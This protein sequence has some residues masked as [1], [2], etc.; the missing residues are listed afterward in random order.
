MRF[1]LI[2]IAA[3]VGCREPQRRPVQPTAAP[4]P[5][6]RPTHWVTGLGFGHPTADA[7]MPQTIAPW[8]SYPIDAWKPAIEAYVPRVR[9]GNQTVLGTSAQVWASY[10]SQ[11]HR[12]LHLQYVNGFLAS[13]EGRPSSDPLSNKDLVAR[14]EVGVDEHGR[15]VALGIIKSSGVVAFDAAVL[16]SFQRAASFGKTPVQCMSA[17][18]I[19]YFHWEMHRGE[20]ECSPAGASPYLLK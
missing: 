19:A 1:A 20:Q 14:V 4:A 10:L 12:A 18:G 2:V 13:I 9:P 7:P 17:D 6:P 5:S 15:I 3:L 11:V 16:E 8:S